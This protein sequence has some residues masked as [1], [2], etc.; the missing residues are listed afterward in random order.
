MVLI[1]RK[2]DV[3]EPREHPSG[4]RVYELFGRQEHLGGSTKHS[5][6]YCVAPPRSGGGRAHYHPEDEETFY[7][8][9]G[10]ARMILDGKEYLAGPGD[11]ILLLPGET[12]QVFVEGDE[13][14]EMIAV[15][16]PAW[17][18]TSEVYVDEKKNGGI[19]G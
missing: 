16:A 1:K 3:E 9:K 19:P 4:A 12:H 18:P 11:A 5:M 7:I 14:L 13:N 6:V 8:L 17:T 2:E 10:K 15:C